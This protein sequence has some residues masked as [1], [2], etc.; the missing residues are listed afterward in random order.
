MNQ[1]SRKEKE[2]LYIRKQTELQRRWKNPIDNNWEMEKW[3]DAELDKGLK[4]VIGQL[5]FEKF[6]G[7]IGA[8]IKTVVMVFVITGVVGLLMFGIRQI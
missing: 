8:I 1:L 5:Q 3:T 6:F 2:L 7:G 4:D